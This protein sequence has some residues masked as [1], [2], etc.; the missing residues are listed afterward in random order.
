MKVKDSVVLVT[1]ANRGIGKG[2]VEEFLNAGAKKIYLAVR[3][4]KSVEDLV[5]KNPEKLIPLELDVTKDDLIRKVAE[6][7]RDV[8]I[9]INN[10]GVLYGG[11]LFDKDRIEHARKEM[12][13]NYFGPLAMVRAFAPVLK[14]N[15]GGAVLNVSSIAGLIAFP[16]IPTYCTSKAA[17]YFLTQ[18]MR[19]EMKAQGTQVMSIHPGPVDTD[20][21][22]DFDMPKVTPN[23]VA[24]EAIRALEAG[25]D[26]LFPDPYAKEL[27]AMFRKDPALAEKEVMKSFEPSVQAA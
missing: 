11:S 22:R 26:M 4:P 16:G 15:G 12:E 3:N 19:M 13:T 7:A 6:K 8:T 9:L 24:Q 20:M 23:R 21:A 14:T 2:F 1:G 10:A 27:Y 5:R 25:E 17:V 18:E